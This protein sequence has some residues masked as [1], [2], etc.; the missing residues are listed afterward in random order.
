[1]I[2]IRQFDDE[3]DDELDDVAVDFLF[4]ETSEPEETTDFDSDFS[5]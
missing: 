2:T 4:E 1:M 3:L 5:P